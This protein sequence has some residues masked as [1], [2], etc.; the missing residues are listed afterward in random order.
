MSPTTSREL[1]T[2][3]AGAMIGVAGVAFSMTVVAVSFAGGQFGPRLIGNFMRDRGNQITL[4]AFAATFVYCITAL[5]WVGEEGDFDPWLTTHGALVLT[6]ACVGVFIYFIHHVPETIN[7]GTITA[8]VGRR[9]QRMLE[10]G[11]FPSREGTA[12]KMGSVGTH[13]G[14]IASEQTGYV[15]RIEV[16]GLIELAVDRGITM[17][18]CC[19]PG[20]FVAVGD[21]IVRLP[22]DAADHEALR[23]M[24][25][26]CVAIGRERTGEQNCLFLIDELVEI[27][28]RAL[29]PGVNDPF[30][31]IGCIHWL[32]AGISRALDREDPAP[33]RADVS[34]EACVSTPIVTF[35]LLVEH[36]LGASIQYVAPDRNASVAML[37]A[38]GT[39]A[40]E[41]TMPQRRDLLLA[42][43]RH[44]VQAAES[45]LSVERDRAL[46]RERWEAAR[47]AA[48][49]VPRSGA[50][51]HAPGV[52]PLS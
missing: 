22:P 48:R 13:E 8:S 21:P 6:G 20:D 19:R 35:E 47:A 29:S 43:G 40:R 34:G 3:I 51:G 1:L 2:T 14:C 42:R 26:E 36:A 27:L 46:L 41:A 49:A 33:L 39:L 30:T 44:L 24:V 38:I 25:R 37:E 7:V 32:R 28:A 17:E 52:S 5:R 16:V 4:G 45:S 9:L 10:E 12:A 18:L 23:A 11:A 31:A 50:Q 15:A